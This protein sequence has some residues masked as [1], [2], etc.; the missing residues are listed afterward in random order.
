MFD[1]FNDIEQHIIDLNKNE[2]YIFVYYQ[3]PGSGWVELVPQHWSE[4]VEFSNPTSGFMVWEDSYYRDSDSETKSNNYSRL[5]QLYETIPNQ[6]RLK[7]V[8]YQQQIDENNDRVIV[9]YTD[10]TNIN[11]IDDERLT[12]YEKDEVL[13]SGLLTK[14]VVYG[15]SDIP[16]ALSGEYY[17]TDGTA[18]SLLFKIR[19][20]ID[21]V[22]RHRWE[23]ISN[24]STIWD[25]NLNFSRGTI[26]SS[27]DTPF[28][29]G[30]NLNPID[31]LTGGV[32][33]YNPTLYIKDIDIITS[34]NLEH[35]YPKLQP[36]PC[37]IDGKR[38]YIMENASGVAIDLT[39]GLTPLPN[40]I[41]IFHKIILDTV[42]V[43]PEI[44]YL[45]EDV[46]YELTTKDYVND[47][48]TVHELNPDVARKRAYLTSDMGFELNLS[49]GEYA[50]DY[51]SNMIYSSGITTAILYWDEVEVPE[52]VIIKD[53]VMDLNP[54]NDTSLGYDEYFLVVG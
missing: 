45:Y 25:I 31:N 18:K 30:I 36:G 1:Y 5:L 41:E 23:N 17:N 29:S 14:P 32:D 51:N 6:S 43:T 8:Y 26:P 28:E 35:W 54:L 44:K 3:S 10:Q 2:Q 46:D 49:L 7:V 22:Y 4:S 52:E 34:G 27:Y 15:L 11:N 20:K 24:R 50:I 48:T 40:G 16:L 37:Y 47:I 42:D 39:T 12:Y 38:Y 13:I 9:R 21:S 19:D 33:Y 53:P